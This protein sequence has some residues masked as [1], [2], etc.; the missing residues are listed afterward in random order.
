MLKGGIKLGSGASAVKSV[1]ETPQLDF[2]PE[3]VFHCDEVLKGDVNQYFFFT[4][5]WIT[6]G[7]GSGKQKYFSR[8]GMKKTAVK[9]GQLKLFTSELMFLNKFWDPNTVPNPTCVYVGA[10][11][12]IHIEF[13]AKMFP[14]ITFHLYDSRDFHKPLYD[15][16]NVKIF[17][18]YFTNEDIKL[19]AN[20]NDI[21]FVS[22]IRNLTYSKSQRMTEEMERENV[23][24]STTDMKMQMD[25]VQK[26][27]PVKASLKFL[28]PYSYDWMTNYDFEY[29]DGDIYKQAWTGQTSTET[30]FIPDLTMPLKKWNTQI[31][32]NIMFYHNNVVREHI[33]YIN[34]LTNINEPISAELGLLQDFDSTFFVMTVKEY[35]LKFMKTEPTPSQVLTLCKY[36]ISSVSKKSFTIAKIRLGGPENYTFDEEDGED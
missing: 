27:K 29:L 18:R 6:V 16:E 35:L 8:K 11:P 5:G 4:D 30:R 36:I 20:R 24:V 34:P 15:L 10:A 33:K 13:L 32:E 23:R 21:F 26:I 25:W 7:D 3:P 22:D 14:K 19:Y 2:G 28:L 12:G 1:A 9:W 17:Q 31:Y